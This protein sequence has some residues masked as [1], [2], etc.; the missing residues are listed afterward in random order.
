M[1][2]GDSLSHMYEW[3]FKGN[4]RFAISRKD[5]MEQFCLYYH[6]QCFVGYKRKS[7]DLNDFV[8]NS[9]VIRIFFNMEMIY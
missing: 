7:E 5:L 9:F 4:S 2:Y 3:Q 1:Y 6:F 8:V